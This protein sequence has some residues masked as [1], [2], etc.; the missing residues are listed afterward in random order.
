ML[1]G[2]GVDEAAAQLLEAPL[3]VAQRVGLL[4]VGV[5]HEVELAEHV[6]DHRQLVGDEQ[7]HVGRAERIGLLAPSGSS[8]RRAAPSRSRSSRPGRRRSAA[9]PA[10]ARRGGASSQARAYSN[11]SA[12]TSS[13]QTSV[14]RA[15]RSRRR[16]RPA[17]R[18]D[19]LGAGQADERVAAE[20]LAADHRFEQVGIGSAGELHVDRERRVEVG[21]RLGE[22]RDAA[23]AR[24]R[25]RSK[26]GF[27]HNS[28]P[29]TTRLLGN[30]GQTT[31]NG[32][33]RSAPGAPE[34]GEK[35]CGELVHDGGNYTTFASWARIS[36]MALP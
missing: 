10:P 34:A 11:G 23:V 29:A 3:R 20:A 24:L 27:G 32:R 25:E 5:D 26:F 8:S 22:H 30:C 16:T 19:A 36:A 21:A 35:L 14:P 6:V 13:R 4:R 2:S 28:L 33:A 17:A 12:S 31:K 18:L 7:Q 9:P 1:P 15:S